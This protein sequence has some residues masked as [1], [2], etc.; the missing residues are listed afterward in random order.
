MA[1]SKNET[2][3]Q[4]SPNYIGTFLHGAP[5]Q[6][7]EEGKKV[8]VEIEATSDEE[9]LHKLKQQA[10]AHLKDSPGWASG[11]QVVEKK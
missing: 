11:Y 4:T 9:A 6:L 7:E 10:S 5:H 1:T 3:V 8:T 2:R